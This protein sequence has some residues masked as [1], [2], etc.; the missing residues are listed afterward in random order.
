MPKRKKFPKLM[1]KLSVTIGTPLLWEDYERR[2]ST[3]KE[4]AKK[5]TEDSEKTLTEMQK[6]HTIKSDTN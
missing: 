1:R 6:T 4:A 2:S 3:A 5:I